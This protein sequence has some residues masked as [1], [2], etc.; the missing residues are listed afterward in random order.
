MPGL[1]RTSMSQRPSGMPA[2]EANRSQSSDGG[3][4]LGG[5]VTSV[6]WSRPTASD[7]RSAIAEMCWLRQN[8][9]PTFS[10]SSGWW[11]ASR[12][13]SHVFTPRFCIVSVHIAG[14]ERARSRAVRTTWMSESAKA[15]LMRSILGRCRGARN[16]IEMID[17]PGHLSTSSTSRQ[18][19]AVRLEGRLLGTAVV[20]QVVDR[21]HLV[22]PAI[23]REPDVVLLRAARGSGSARSG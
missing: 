9:W 19:V 17:V 22:A 6:K 2:T 4:P 5:T 7:Q 12:N 14:S 21:H 16:S 1:L 15:S 13:S 23:A 20:H 3:A 8:Q 18:P 11:T 10:P